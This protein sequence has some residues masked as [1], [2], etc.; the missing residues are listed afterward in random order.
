MS[1]AAVV[2]KDPRPGAAVHAANFVRLPD[3]L[4]HTKCGMSRFDLEITSK[5][6]TCQRCR[7]IVAK[8]ALA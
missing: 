8:E 2:M 1:W 5:A 7:A 4:R 6:L 3:N